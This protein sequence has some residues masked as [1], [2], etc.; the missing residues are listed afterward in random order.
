MVECVAVLNGGNRARV[1]VDTLFTGDV[2]ERVL[3]REFKSTILIFSV[4]KSLRLLGKQ[5]KVVAGDNLGLDA[6]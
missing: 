4:D 3:N 5:R 1:C 2:E 6:R